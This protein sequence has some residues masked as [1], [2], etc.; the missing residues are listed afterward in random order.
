LS[1]TRSPITSRSNWAKESSTLRVSRPMLLVVLNDCHPGRAGGAPLVTRSPLQS[2]PLGGASLRCGRLGRAP[3]CG[4]A[5]WSLS[6]TE[7]VS[8][9]SKRK[10]EI[11]KWRAETDAR[12]PPARDQKASKLQPKPPECRRFSR[13]PSAEGASKAKGSPM[14][15]PVIFIITRVE[16]T[17]RSAKRFAR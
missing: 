1:R 8:G 16:R 5:N 14:T 2:R 10:L 17:I 15:T 12:K 11:G 7:P 6:R 4:S 3:I 13:T 9:T